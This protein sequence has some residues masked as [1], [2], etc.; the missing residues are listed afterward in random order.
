M[1]G[2]SAMEMTP[3]HLLLHAIPVASCSKQMTATLKIKEVPVKL[4]WNRLPR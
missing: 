1:D 4:L 3:E 2:G